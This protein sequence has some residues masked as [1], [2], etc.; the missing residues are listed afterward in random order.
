MAK[1]TKQNRE[2]TFLSNHGHV[3]VQINQD[4]ESRIRD[5]AEA[6]GITERSTQLILADLEAAGYITT[7]R[8]GRRNSYKVNANLK[9][10]H[11]SEDSKPIGSLLKIFL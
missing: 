11:P 7:T 8:V 1:E 3:L 5:I 10:R 9:F 2:W 6:V 4:P